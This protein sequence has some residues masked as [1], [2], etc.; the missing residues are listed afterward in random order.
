MTAPAIVCVQ[1]IKLARARSALRDAGRV[2]NEKASLSEEK[3]PHGKPLKGFTVLRDCLLQRKEVTGPSGHKTY[4]VKSTSNGY[5]KH[6]KERFYYT[7]AQRENV[8]P[9]ARDIAA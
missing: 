2:E 3:C 6:F 8:D 5:V 9:R 1:Y 7:A 4:L